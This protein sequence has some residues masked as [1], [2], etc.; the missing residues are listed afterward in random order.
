MA[1]RVS[2][3]LARLRA[4]FGEAEAQVDAT[5]GRA[6]RASAQRLREIL[7]RPPKRWPA[8]LE[9]K[10]LT[11]A[12]RAE[13]EN[14][15]A[16]VLPRQ[17]TRRRISSSGVGRRWLRHARYRRRGLVALALIIIPIFG[18]AWLAWRH[19]LPHA[20]PVR[21]M[22]PYVITWTLPGGQ[23]LRREET[24]QTEFVWFTRAGRNYLR[25]WFDGRGYG[26][27]EIP[28]AFTKQALVLRR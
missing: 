10:T 13:L 4:R 27:V 26:E 16:K 3:A 24:A 18:L 1:N 22:A 8:G 28:D 21:L 15:I 6:R 12:D 20:V 14:E 11:P 19:T 5:R 7:A 25:R 23:I 9:D 17:G 2:S